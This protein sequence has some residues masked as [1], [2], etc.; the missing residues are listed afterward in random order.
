[1][2][3]YMCTT[4]SAR[5]RADVDEFCILTCFLVGSVVRK[6][7]SVLIDYSLSLEICR[8]FFALCSRAHRPEYMRAMTASVGEHRG[9][10]VALRNP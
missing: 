4:V 6:C 5:P 10:R 9:A 1:M 3:V 7:T 8:S 2:F